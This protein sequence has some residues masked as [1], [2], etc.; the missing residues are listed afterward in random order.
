VS[1]E[2]IMLVDILTGDGFLPMEKR[3]K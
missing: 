2:Q 3:H 1:A